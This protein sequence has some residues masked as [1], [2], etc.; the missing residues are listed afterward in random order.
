MSRKMAE[1]KTEIGA[2]IR[3][4]RLRKGLK[5]R[6]LADITG[7][8]VTTIYR[9][10]AGISAPRKSVINA[11]RAALAEDCKTA[12]PDPFGCRDEILRFFAAAEDLIR[13]L[14]NRP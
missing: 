1:P 2:E 5:Q 6:E 4:A 14:K 12:E 8:S 9:L 7:V 3:A 11:I 13:A 10:E